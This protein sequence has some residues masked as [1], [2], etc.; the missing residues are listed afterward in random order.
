MIFA[1]SWKNPPLKKS[2]IDVTCFPSLQVP[3][4]SDRCN[5]AC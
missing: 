1:Y 3:Q 5:L 2:I 4:P